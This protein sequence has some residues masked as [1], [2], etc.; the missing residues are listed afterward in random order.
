MQRNGHSNGARHDGHRR[1]RIVIV[2]ASLAGLSAAETLRAEGFTGSLT[3]IGDE[4]YLPYDR[5][6]LSKEV[7]A[8]WFPAEHTQLPRFATLTGIEWRLGVTATGLDL[9]AKQVRLADG[10]RVPYDRLLIATGTRARPW[11][12]PAEA[13]L[14]GV[15]TLRG[16]DD[17]QR[18]RQRLADKPRR[19]L[20]IGGGFTGSEIASVCRE[21][22]LP[23]TVIERETAPLEGALG[24]LMAARMARLQR[25][26]GVD[27]RCQ[28]TVTALEENANGLLC[29]AQLSDGSSLDA[30]VAVVALGAI[31]N[32]EWLRDTGLAVGSFGVAC[33]AGC[34]V[35]DI[36]AIV[37]DD[38]F[39]A[40]D[41]ARFPHPLFDYQFMALEHWGN[42]WEQAQVAAHNM[43]CAPA[44]RR[45]HVA[46]PAFWS[47]QFGINIKSVGVP[48]AADQIMITQGALDGDEPRFVVVYGKE[49]RVVAAVAF[50]HAKWL[51][52]Y[53]RLIEKAAP[54]PPALP[55]TEQTRLAGPVPAA[56][57]EPRVLSPDA[58]VALT[59]YDPNEQRVAWILRSPASA[60][61]RVPAHA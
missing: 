41:V 22:G 35:F 29:R 10:Q 49:G 2:G 52:Y 7:L 46:V 8:G 37:G 11:P 9:A 1:E 56:F 27:L 21:L 23:V 6:P 26:H 40:G 36:N 5:P 53:R 30:E 33:D 24:G 43:I 51:E 42:A 45:P 12:N 60:P 25:D 57:P 47:S 34:R 4:P 48:S 17:A 19:V 54:F 38:V 13:A 32:T 61:P 59:G 16:R 39:V 18:L 20:V 50:D 15:F 55:V 31:R 58:T 3:V 14:E 28:T 44:D